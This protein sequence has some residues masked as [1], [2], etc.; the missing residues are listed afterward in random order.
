MKNAEMIKTAEAQWKNYLS[1]VKFRAIV[2]TLAMS[3][4]ETVF[5][6]G[7]IIGVCYNEEAKDGKV[8]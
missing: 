1:D 7:F 6:H 8:A 2:E 3:A 4:F 5:K